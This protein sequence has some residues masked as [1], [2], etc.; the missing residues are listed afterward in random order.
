MCREHVEAIDMEGFKRFCDSERR[1]IV[2]VQFVS[3]RVFGIDRVY[4][5]LAT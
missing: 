1:E 5:M 3:P 4:H 2:C